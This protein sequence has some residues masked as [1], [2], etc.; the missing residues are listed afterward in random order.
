[1]KK[2]PYALLLALILP[3]SVL[4]GGWPQP[5]GK[6][7]F[8]LSEFFLI[9][10]GFYN[11]DG[12]EQLGDFPTTTIYITNFY[13]EYGLTDRVTVGTYIPLFY[14]AVR[15][16]QQFLS[17]A[18][19][20]EGDSRSSIG[21]I[22]VFI[23]YGLI[24]NKPFVLSAS[25]TLG[26]P[27]GKSNGLITS[28]DGEFNQLL[29]LE[30]G[31]GFQKIPLFLGLGAGYNNRT[32]GFSSEV[33]IDAEIGYTFSEKITLIVKSRNLVSLRNR[34]APDTSN[35][36]IFGDR[37]STYTLGP[38]IFI[39]NVFK[40]IGFSANYFFNLGGR[41]TLVGAPFSA[42]FFMKL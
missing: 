36:G 19:D 21:D 26:V 7:F 34:E 4:G 5:K 33:H 2:L 11:D 40:N 9:G 38:E 1:M 30:A 3:A 31:Y 35:T 29:K 39:N 15:N 32:R 23:K 27:T 25:L 20:N 13:G 42:G 6:G 16:T 10:T 28:G 18:P 8:K 24:Y 14:R 37:I 12:S 41:N 22:D 17:G